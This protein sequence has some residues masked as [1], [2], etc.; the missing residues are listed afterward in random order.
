MLAGYSCERKLAGI[1][2][3]SGLLPLHDKFAAV[4]VNPWPMI[5]F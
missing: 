2:G 4:S 1:V 5:D 3:L